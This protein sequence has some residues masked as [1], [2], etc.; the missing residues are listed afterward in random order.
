MVFYN[1]LLETMP[2][3]HS[4]YLLFGHIYILFKEYWL[5]KK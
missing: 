3:N 1:T 2:P 4:V 5:Y